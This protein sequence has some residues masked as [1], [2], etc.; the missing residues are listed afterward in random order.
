[1]SL[2]YGPASIYPLGSISN[3]MEQLCARS[4]WSD[5]AFTNP[6]FSF[7]YHAPLPFSSK[8]SFKSITR[9]AFLRVLSHVELKYQ[10]KGWKDIN[11]KCFPFP[12]YYFV[13][14]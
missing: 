7:C 13:F 9:A 10:K 4:I 14:T 2:S 5:D 3:I 11:T 6:L 12:E 8:Q 1:M